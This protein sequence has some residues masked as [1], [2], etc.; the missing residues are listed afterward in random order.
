MNNQKSTKLKVNT[1]EPVITN[2]ESTANNNNKAFLDKKKFIF[3][4][5]CI[6]ASIIIVA[7]T[8]VYVLKINFT[9]FFKN[10]HDSI[11]TNDLAIL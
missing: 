3:I 6:I 1:T 9:E 11:K 2:F 8:I 5:L 4:S 10:V 7:L